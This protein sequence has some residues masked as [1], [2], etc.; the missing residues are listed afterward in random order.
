M[1]TSDRRTTVAWTRHVVQTQIMATA[2]GREP[3]R[4]PG[5]PKSSFA[6]G[7]RTGRKGRHADLSCLHARGQGSGKSG[8]C[9][10]GIERSMRVH[11]RPGHD[12]CCAASRRLCSIRHCHQQSCRRLST[13]R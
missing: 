2:R 1:K 9:F 11:D 6:E 10:K 8:G 13:R 4:R 3:R 7:V 12:G 5:S